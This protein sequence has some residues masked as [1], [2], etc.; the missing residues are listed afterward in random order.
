MFIMRD[1]IMREASK[2]VDL[3]AI[4]KSLNT[5][6]TLLDW[7]WYLNT[8]PDLRKGGVTTEEATRKHWEENGRRENR[9]C[10]CLYARKHNIKVRCDGMKE[11][12][13]ERCLGLLVRNA[14]Q[15]IIGV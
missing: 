6:N 7:I 9:A 1:S 5:E 15:K 8:Y 12:C 4:A 14:N 2:H 11:H 10:N 13:V 3:V